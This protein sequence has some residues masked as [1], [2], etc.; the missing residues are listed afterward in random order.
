MAELEALITVEE[1]DH[2]AHRVWRDANRLEADGRPIEQVSFG[3]S[4]AT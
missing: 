3:R 1:I 4:T 2:R